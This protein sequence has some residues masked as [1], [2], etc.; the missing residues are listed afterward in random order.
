MARAWSRVFC[1]NESILYHKNRIISPIQL[2]KLIKTKHYPSYSKIA[3]CYRPMT[4]CSDCRFRPSR[5]AKYWSW[6]AER[7]PKIWVL[8]GHFSFLKKILVKWVKNW[9]KAV[10]IKQ[11]DWKN[12]HSKQSYH[13]WNLYLHGAP[14]RS[15]TFL[16]VLAGRTV[17]N[18][19]SPIGP[20]FKF[21][22]QRQKRH[23]STSKATTE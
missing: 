16:T 21:R 14:D 12:V 11:S 5:G 22:C 15:A 6:P 17:K 18:L 9:N 10:T 20:G 8:G 1:S 23:R 19:P 13:H 7:K 4:F 2:K 3:W